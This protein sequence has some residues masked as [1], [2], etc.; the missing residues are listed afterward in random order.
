MDFRSIKVYKKL[1]FLENQLDG[2]K[3]L[4]K[5]RADLYTRVL[6]SLEAEL[7]PS[8]I[9]EI[10][11]ESALV[12]SKRKRWK[13]TRGRAG[14]GPGLWLRWQKNRYDVFMRMARVCQAD[15][16]AIAA[17]R[18]SRRKTRNSCVSLEARPDLFSITFLRLFVSRI[19]P[20]LPRALLALL[21]FP[22][23]SPSP[24]LVAIKSDLTS[25]YLRTY[26]VSAVASPERGPF[27]S[28]FFHDIRVHRRR[29]VA[30][31]FRL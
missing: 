24:L 30:H 13:N 20:L 31:E 8:E 27:P 22:R 6:H 25:I 17:R 5:I 21:A 3:F 12:E 2:L 7:G 1:N 10:S 15:G 23:L 4:M 9:L 11:A 16:I 18:I 28:S 29:H 26:P 19:F 14:C